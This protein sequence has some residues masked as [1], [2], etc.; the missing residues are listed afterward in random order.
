[1]W[2]EDLKLAAD[3][4]ASDPPTIDPIFLH[5]VRPPSDLPWPSDLP[6]CD[7]LIEFYSICDGG[8]FGPAVTFHAKAA[9]PEETQKWI[10]TLREYSEQGDILTAG[11]H[12]VIANEADGTPW[13]FDG[14]DR[15]VQRFYW[16]EATWCDPRF[17]SHDAFMN[18]VMYSDSG[19]K[20]WVKAMEIIRNQNG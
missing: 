15:S 8:F 5:E 3:Y 9:L 17:P 6:A 19:I 2:T 12:I 13:V 11:R 20:E 7:S 18:H 14:D 10:E 16:K 1:M 4:Y